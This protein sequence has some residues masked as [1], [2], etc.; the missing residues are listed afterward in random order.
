MPA[1][2]EAVER[3]TQSHGRALLTALRAQAHHSV[4]DRVYDWLLRLVTADERLKLDLF[5]FVDVLPALH[6]PHAVARHLEEYLGERGLDLPSGVARLARLMARTAPGEWVMS[7]AAQAGT[8][9]LAQRFIAGADARQVLR[10]ARHLRR[11]DLAFSADLL[12]EA[13]TSEE[14]AELYQQRY[15]ALLRDLAAADLWPPNPVTDQAPFGPLP[16]VNLSIK[17]SSLYARFD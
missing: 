16:R 5:R 17:L 9:L 8:H 10:A 12:G 11:S 3:A 13:V 2:G 14:E 15:L 4:T 1:D 7:E 6:G